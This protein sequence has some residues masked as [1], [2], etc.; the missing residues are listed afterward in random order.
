MDGR[1]RDPRIPS[2]ILAGEV[3]A[4]GFL[5]YSPGAGCPL[6]YEYDHEFTG[7]PAHYRIGTYYQSTHEPVDHGPGE[8]FEKREGRDRD[9]L[10]GQVTE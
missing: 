2:P 10:Q 9:A 8:P 7:F 4:H 5:G 6:G 3:R 1:R